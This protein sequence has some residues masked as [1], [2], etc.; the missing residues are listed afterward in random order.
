MSVLTVGWSRLVGKDKNDD[1]SI[2]YKN[3]DC[4]YYSKFNS[5]VT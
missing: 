1:F 4:G 5:W 2:F 3:T